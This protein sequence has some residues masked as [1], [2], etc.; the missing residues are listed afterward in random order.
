M[1]R[2]N[3]P[4][5]KTTLTIAAAT[6]LVLT[7]CSTA[8]TPAPTSTQPT[9]DVPYTTVWS[10]ADGINLNTRPAEL[11]RAT[12]ESGE[13]SAWAGVDHSFPGFADAIA[14]ANAYSGYWGDTTQP[15]SPDNLPSRTATLFARHIA[16]LRATDNQ[17]TARVC[18]LHL[19]LVDQDVVLKS[20][21][22][23]SS[24]RSVTVPTS[25]DV[26]LAKPAN[27]TPGTSGQTDHAPEI[28]NPRALD[29]P[30]WNVFSPWTIRSI[31]L[32]ETVND[33][34]GNEPEC[35]AWWRQKYPGWDGT[36]LAFGPPTPITTEN[37][38]FEALMITRPGP[39]NYPEWLGPKGADA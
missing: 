12:V 22:Y 38:F 28:H 34:Y 37:G 33:Y 16:S 30:D 11:V 32:L 39:P 19:P 35:M 10:A 8:N 24:F 7:G 9:P 1:R 15:S 2:R 6:A 18:N 13:M 36:S 17:I 3:R 27:T 31:A 29:T 5:T 21:G 23:T 26:T 20:T 25:L 4:L 14:N